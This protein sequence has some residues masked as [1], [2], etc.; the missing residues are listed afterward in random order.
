M[1][2]G[3]DRRVG[4]VGGGLYTVVSVISSTSVTLSNTGNGHGATPGS[5]V[6][7]GSSVQIG[8]TVFCHGSDSQSGVEMIGE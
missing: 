3:C 2:V 8:A 7:S 5:T 6:A 4:G 1:P